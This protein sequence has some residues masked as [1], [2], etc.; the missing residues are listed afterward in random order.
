M[1]T[2]ST[3]LQLNIKLQSDLRKVSAFVAITNS[4]QMWE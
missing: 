4:A 2:V 1:K 3:W